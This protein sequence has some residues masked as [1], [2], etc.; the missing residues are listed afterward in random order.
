MDNGRTR[1]V[2]PSVVH[3]HCKGEIWPPAVE[4]KPGDSAPFL[5]IN[6]DPINQDHGPESRD[7]P[8]FIENSTSSISLDN[9]VFVTVLS[10]GRTAMITGGGL[11]WRL[12]TNTKER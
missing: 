1:P 5:P 12:P 9:I 6:Q 4:L 10:W 11:E 7:Q 8:A 3:H 2:A